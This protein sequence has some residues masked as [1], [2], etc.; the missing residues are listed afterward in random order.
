MNPEE[1][2]KALGI[3]LPPAPEALGSYVPAR[4]SGNLVFLS[5]I[6]PLVDGKVLRRGKVGAEL[7]LEEARREAQKAAINA[8]AIIKSFAGGLENV[9][10]CVKVTGYVAS[11]PGFA[12]QHKVLNAVSDL[13]AEVFGERG[14]HARAAVGV[15][16]LPLDAP[17]EVEFVFEVGG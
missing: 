6:L 13:V 9:A 8:L 10:G 16:E 2:L 5:G 1:R 17:L 3:E 12:E 4:R 14:R 7:T 11:A 15:G